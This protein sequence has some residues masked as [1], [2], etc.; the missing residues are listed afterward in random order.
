MK[1]EYSVLIIYDIS[2]DKMRNE[3]FNT[4]SGYGKNIQK[5]S[6]LCI[7]NNRLYKKMLLDLQKIKINETDSICIYKMYNFKSITL[8]KHIDVY[9]KTYLIL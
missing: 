3:L 2:N 9:E 7:L 1:K 6:F 8:G 5:S 4:L